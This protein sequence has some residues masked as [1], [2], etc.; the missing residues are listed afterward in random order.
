MKLKEAYRP[1]CYAIYNKTNR[2]QTITFYLPIGETASKEESSCY[3]QLSLWLLLVPA[4]TWPVTSHIPRFRTRSIT[5]T[6]DLFLLFLT[7]SYSLFSLVQRSSTTMYW[8]AAYCIKKCAV[9]ICT[10]HF[11]ISFFVSFWC[12]QFVPFAQQCNFADTYWAAFRHFWW[13][14]D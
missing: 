11:S 2:T 14:A 12:S 10:A 1:K 13:I 9:Q 5:T 8:S 6:A 3:L 7:F 4:C